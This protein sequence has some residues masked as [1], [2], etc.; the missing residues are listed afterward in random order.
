MLTALAEVHTGLFVSIN[1]QAR[2][3]VFDKNI[4]VAMAIRIHHRIC[5][6]IKPVRK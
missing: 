6:G 5:Y 2:P 3:E 4:L 1:Y